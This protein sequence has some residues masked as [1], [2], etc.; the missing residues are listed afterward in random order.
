MNVG[1]AKLQMMDTLGFSD[2]AFGI[3]AGIMFVGI[4]CWKSRAPDGA[5]RRAQ[6]LRTHHGADGI[7]GDGLRPDAR[8]V[9][10][11]EILPG[12]FEA[13]FFPGVVLY[14]SYWF[15]ASRRGAITLFSSAAAVTGVI[16]GPSAG[17]TMKYLHQLGGLEG[18]QWVYLTQRPPGHHIGHGGRAVLKNGPTPGAG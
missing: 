8:A 7:R 2:T 9:L 18:W 12:V 6:D 16:S 15:P 11:G 1:F 10:C 3:G 14:L 17:A 4:A 5:D 13:G